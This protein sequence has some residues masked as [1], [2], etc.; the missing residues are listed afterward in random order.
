MY[1]CNLANI[2]KSIFA[3]HQVSNAFGIGTIIPLIKDKSRNLNDTEIC[4]AI[5]QIPIICKVFESCTLSTCEHLLIVDQLQLVL[6]TS[7]I[8]SSYTAV[9][10]FIYRSSACLHCCYRCFEGF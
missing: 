10:Y 7:H 4:R 2:F 6:S 8:C 5:T 1:R 9:D 3:H